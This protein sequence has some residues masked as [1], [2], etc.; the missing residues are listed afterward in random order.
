M[1]EMVRAI[2][3]RHLPQ[4]ENR[5]DSSHRVRCY[6]CHKGRTDPRP[7]PEILGDAYQAGGVDSPAALYRSRRDRYFGGDAYDFRVGVLAGIATALADRDAFDDAVAMAALNVD[8][9]PNEAAAKQNWV[10]LALERRVK[11]DGVEAALAEFEGMVP[12]LEVNVVSPGLLD[13]LAWRLYRQD[14]K[15]AALAIFRQNLATFPQE[16]VPNESMAVV[17]FDR[18]EHESAFRILEQWIERHPDHDRARRLLVN[19]RAR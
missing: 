3:D 5:I 2:N 9:N 11:T 13:G 4:L 16:Y 19:L 1:L 14:H 7:L 6:T 17:S 12:N 15:T 8:V 10:R 18:G